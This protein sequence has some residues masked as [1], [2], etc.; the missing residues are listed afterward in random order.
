MALVPIFQRHGIFL[1]TPLAS[2]SSRPHSFPDSATRSRAVLHKAARRPPGTVT[3]HSHV[4]FTDEASDREYRYQL[5]FPKDADV[6]ENRISV[7]TL[8]GAGLIGLKPGQTILWPDRDGR[9]RRLK[10]MSVERGSPVT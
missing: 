5:V 2:G 4:T 1:G 9:E 8:V 3:M 7:L 6:A 10:V